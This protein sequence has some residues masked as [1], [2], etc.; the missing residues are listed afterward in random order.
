MINK[1]LPFFL[2]SEEQII[3]YLLS[4]NKDFALI[5]DIKE[6]WFYNEKLKYLFK[7]CLYLIKNNIEIDV[8]SIAQNIKEETLIKIGGV[9]S[10]IK[11]QDSFISKANIKYHIKQIKEAYNKRILIETLNKSLIAAYDGATSQNIINDI[12]E[13]AINILNDNSDNKTIFNTKELMQVGFKNILEAKK[14]GNN[15]KGFATGYKMIDLSLNGIQKKDLYI[16]GAR[17][18]IGKTAF[19]LNLAEGLVTNNCKVA[20]FSLEMSAEKISNRIL[21]MLSFTKSNIVSKGLLQ[22]NELKQLNTLAKD[23]SKNDNF[24]L[25]DDGNINMNQIM[26][27]CKNIKLVAGGLDVIFIDH[28]GLISANKKE[29]RNLEI[30][31]ITRQCKIIAK[32]LN[33]AVVLLSQLSRL[34]EQ[35]YDHRPLLSDLRESGSIEQDADTVILLYRDEYYNKET[36]EKGVLEVNFAKNRDGSTGLIKMHC[37]LSIQKITELDYIRSVNNE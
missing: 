30:S 37:N 24:F 14:R 8:I 33:V 21:S 17:P 9:S 10:L 3:G 34:P 28:L 18:S 35:R 16:I 20:F 6:E 1:K 36:E 27:K 22:D 29:N 26:A 5:S 13:T 7:L 31:E 19:A 32:E 25:I 11:I 23:F 15:I 4:K 12:E 2:E